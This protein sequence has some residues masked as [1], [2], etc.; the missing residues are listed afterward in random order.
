MTPMRVL[1]A[2]AVAAAAA[3]STAAAQTVAGVP[4][5][6]TATA[7]PLTVATF[8][9]EYV[10]T[11]AGTSPDAA[12]A[13]RCPVTLGIDNTVAVPRATEDGRG[14]GV[15]VTDALR[16]NGEATCESPCLAADIVD[17]FCER[18]DATKEAQVLLFASREGFNATSPNNGSTL[19]ANG[20]EASL[21]AADVAYYTGRNT[22]ELRCGGG[23]NV[24]ADARSY[25][26][27][28]PTTLPLS[29][30]LP[31]STPTVVRS[32]RAGIRRILLLLD[33]EFDGTWCGYAGAAAVARDRSGELALP[34]GV[35][36]PS[37]PVPT[38]LP[39]VIIEL[40]A[41]GDGADG[42][43]GRPG[44]DGQDGADGAD[45]ADG[46]GG[47]GGNGGAGGRGGRVAV[48]ARASFS[49]VRSR[50]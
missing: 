15:V 45:G 13:A 48:A 16:V 38:P 29:F 50:D 4:G 26:I 22:G 44:C 34:D 46:V 14:V 19:P 6:V 47:N 24:V 1:C 20:L 10:L 31:S 37:T 32:L 39:V 12:E 11:K 35:S 27:L 8:E 3:A 49:A 36:L 41:S 23:V 21:A 7:A 42:A 9:G 33:D 43:D 30:E 2:V 5:A 18:G 40:P 25:W 17:R 28:P